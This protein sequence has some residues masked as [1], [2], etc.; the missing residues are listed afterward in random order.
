MTTLL[1]DLS[2]CMPKLIH[3]GNTN[4]EKHS[5]FTKTTEKLE[6]GSRATVL[7]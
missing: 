4:Y 7:G 1:D 6:V 2:F 3:Q 5:F